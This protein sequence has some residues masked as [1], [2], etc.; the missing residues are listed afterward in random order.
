[1]NKTTKIICIVAGM[2][3]CTCLGLFIGINMG[4][5][6][7]NDLDSINNKDNEELDVFNEIKKE[8]SL[9]IVKEIYYKECKH[10][11][12]SNESQYT[13][14]LQVLKTE[15]KKTNSDYTVKDE[16]TNR[17]VLYKEV[18]GICPQHYNLKEDD[19]GYIAVYEYK[20]GKWVFKESTNVPVSSLKQSVKE[21]LKDGIKIETLENLASLLEELES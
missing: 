16:S 4:K 2:I 20:D 5:N 15:V 8:E 13:K 19:D 18:E 6:M 21:Q 3:I 17:I 7:N 11:I 12:A 14:N 9:D 1:M 10:T